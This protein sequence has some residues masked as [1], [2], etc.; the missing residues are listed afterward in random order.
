MKMQKSIKCVKENLKITMLK[1][2]KYLK[3]RYYCHYTGEYRCAA[4]DMS[5]LKFSVPKNTSI[6]FTMD[7]TIIIILS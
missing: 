5:N 7:L 1:T 6:V 2:K 3:I 4:H